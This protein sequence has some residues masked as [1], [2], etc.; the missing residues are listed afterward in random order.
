M[1]DYLKVHQ[2]QIKKLKCLLMDMTVF[3]HVRHFT[4]EQPYKYHTSIPGYNI[5]DEVLYC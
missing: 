3:M 5:K 1:D 2:L 4:L